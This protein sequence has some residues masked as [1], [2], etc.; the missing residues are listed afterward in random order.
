ME[1]IV[2]I[3]LFPLI[4]I[5]AVNDPMPFPVFLKSGFSTILE[6]EEAPIRVVIGDP[7]SF[8]VERLDRSLAIKA[9]AFEATSNL[10]VYFKSVPPKLFILRASDEVEPTYYKRFETVIQV[11]PKIP[12]KSKPLMTKVTSSVFDPKKD[13]L[14]IEIVVF[15]D[16]NRLLPQWNKVRLNYGS[17]IFQPAKL[18]SE[19]KDVQKDTQVK[20]RFIFYRPDIPKDFKKVSLILPLLGTSKP[21]ELAIGGR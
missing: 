10:F 5:T 1:Y 14:I 2:L 13:Y 9:L 18:W 6:F 21:I 11:Q 15:A 7:Q 4:A 17:K 12:P 19:R 8:Q 20:A 3:I 16:T